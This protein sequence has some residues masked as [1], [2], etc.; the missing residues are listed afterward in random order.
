VTIDG[1]EFVGPKGTTADSGAAI[2]VKTGS[3]VEIN[4]GTFK[5]GKNNTLAA[6]GTLT[7]QGGSYDQDPSAYLPAGYASYAAGTG[8]G[9]M[10]S[11][12]LD[13][14]VVGNRPVIG[15]AEGDVNGGTLILK[16]TST[17][18]G[19]ITWTTITWTK[20]DALSTADGAKDWVKP[21]EGYKF[22][23]GGVAK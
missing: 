16:A 9:V 20:D 21:R 14:K 4:G 6:S 19:T 8:F 3:T 22:F 17:L 12:K 11:I 7:V 18:D 13:I 1:G 5:G 2:N 15:Y 23:T 10:K